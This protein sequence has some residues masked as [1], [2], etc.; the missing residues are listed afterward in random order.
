MKCLLV[1]DI[2][3]YH[4]ENAADLDY[5]AARFGE[6]ARS[7]AYWCVLNQTSGAS[8]SFASVNSSST[9]SETNSTSNP[10]DH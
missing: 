6:R 7:C 10:H 3:E 2:L 1:G 9:S 8:N 5:L 4:P